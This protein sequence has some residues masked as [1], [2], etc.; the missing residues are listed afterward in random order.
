MA[1]INLCAE[2]VDMTVHYR[3]LTHVLNATR[4]HRRVYLTLPMDE[5]TAI[6]AA[7]RAGFAFEGMLEDPFGNG[8]NHACFGHVR[9]GAKG[10]ARD[11]SRDALA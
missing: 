9:R 6:E 4:K 1:K 2:H 3:L 5:R 7:S 10:R 8:V 11:G